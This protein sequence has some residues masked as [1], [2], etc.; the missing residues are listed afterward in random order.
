M[1]EIIHPTLEYKTNKSEDTYLLLTEGLADLDLDLNNE[2][3]E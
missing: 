2:T 3:Y 1:A